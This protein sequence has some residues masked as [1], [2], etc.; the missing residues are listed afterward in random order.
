[1]PCG[2]K[3]VGPDS[4][5]I[6]VVEVLSEATFPSRALPRGSSTYSLA[7]FSPGPELS[8]GSACFAVL[9]RQCFFEGIPVSCLKLSPRLRAALSVSGGGYPPA[10][11]QVDAHAKVFETIC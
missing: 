4:E 11:F 8:P 1:M 3:Y 6:V 7:L 10:T 5:Y 9:L 2:E